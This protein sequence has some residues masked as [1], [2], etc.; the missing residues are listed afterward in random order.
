MK[1]LQRFCT[2]T[3]LVLA[4]TLSVIAGEIPGPGVAKSEPQQQSSITGDISFPGETATGDMPCPGVD[5]LDPATE[6]AL[7]L[8]QSLLALF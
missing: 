5:A 8:F 2:A 7:N 1:K 4:L 6:A 3:A